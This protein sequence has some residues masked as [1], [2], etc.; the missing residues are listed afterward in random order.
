MKLNQF[1]KFANASFGYLFQT[2]ER[3]VESLFG[4][5]LKPEK[6]SVEKC[7][8]A[9]G[10]EFALASIL[11]LRIL[12]SGIIMSVLNDSNDTTTNAMDC[13]VSSR[14]LHILIETS[15][16]ILDQ[17]HRKL[18]RILKFANNRVHG[19]KSNEMLKEIQFS[20]IVLQIH[21]YTS[22]IPLADDDL[23]EIQSRSQISNGCQMETE[24]KKI[25]IPERFPSLASLTEI[26]SMRTTINHVLLGQQMTCEILTNLCC[27]PEQD[28]ESWAES[29]EMELSD[30]VN[31]F[32]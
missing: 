13:T 1:T 20:N 21:D 9:N 29:D 28:V 8:Y 30:E 4:N 31:C 25:L 18:V 10:G 5:L 11:Y 22:L 2:Q 3:G 24:D 23:D 26:N 12:A 17:D 15:S 6:Q 7:K 32:Y 19:T 16:T 27:D 14:V